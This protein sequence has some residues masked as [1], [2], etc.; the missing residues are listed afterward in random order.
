MV[1]G[2][3]NKSHSISCG[4]L[5]LDD[6]VVEDGELWPGKGLSPH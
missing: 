2:V 1:E 5:S 6:G 4:N 3:A